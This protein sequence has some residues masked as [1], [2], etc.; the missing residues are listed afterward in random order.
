MP[1][2]YANAPI[3]DGQEYWDARIQAP[4]N[5]TLKVYARAHFEKDDDADLKGN[6]LAHLLPLG[7]EKADS[8]VSLEGLINGVR[9]FAQGNTKFGET[10]LV[11]DQSYALK[12]DDIAQVRVNW[13]Y[14]KARVVGGG[15]TMSLSFSY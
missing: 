10:I 5:G 15:L 1:T 13:S 6:P 9:V 4:E 12:K 2:I 14:Y 11:W 8:S 3:I 7:E